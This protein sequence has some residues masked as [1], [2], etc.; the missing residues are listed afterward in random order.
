MKL[1]YPED[2]EMAERMLA[3]ATPCVGSG[4]DAHRFGPGDHVTLCG[5]KI[6]HEKGLVGHSDADAGWHALVDAILGALGA[7]RY[8]RAFPAERRAME[9][10]ELRDVSAAL[11]R[12]SPQSK[13][14]ASRMSMSP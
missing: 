6:A 13:A 4:F 7:G 2:F 12:R 10:R 8:R 1:T 11:R 14:R 3:T 9:R 5:V